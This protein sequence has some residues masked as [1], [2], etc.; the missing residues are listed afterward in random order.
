MSPDAAQALRDMLRSDAA[1]L[2]VGILVTAIGI[3]GLL[4]QGLRRASKDRGLVWFGLFAILYGIRLLITTGLSADL[5]G[6][7]RVLLFLIWA[8]TFT[9]GIP[10]AI[11]AWGLVSSEWNRTI[12]ILLGA[13][14]ALAVLAIASYP[15]ASLR[16]ALLLINN[17]LVI[18][19][20]SAFLV[21]LFFLRPTAVPGLKVLRIGFGLFALFV[22]YTNL[23]SANLMPGNAGLE[24]V[25][26]F[27]YI[28][29]LGY[30]G[31]ERMF[32]NEEHLLAIR[33]EL[34]IARQI[35]A[36][37]LPDR[38]PTITGLQ[39]AARYLPMTEVAGDFYEFLVVDSQRLG[40]LIADV[41]GHGVPAALVA[42]MLKVAIAAQAPHADDPAQVMS[43]L[44]SIL[45]GKLQ[46]QFITA[47]YLF[48]DLNAGTGLYSAAGHPPLLH[49][50]AAE[51]AIH[52]VESNGLILGFLPT[53][54][55]ESKALLLGAN[56]RFLLY[57]DGVLEASRNG[58]EFGQ[59]RL[60]ELFGVATTADQICGS[61][62]AAVDHWASGVAS[63]DI[64]VVAMQLDLLPA[65]PQ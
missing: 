17:L 39:L 30:I 48:L 53:A 47:G 31:A 52:A 65:K 23:V 7:R 26:F 22:M 11:F 35:Q 29:F 59:A 49:Y 57:T 42:S 20:T 64:T 13:I 27:I 54:V 6:S 51:T 5:V 2:V 61:V 4:L 1:P 44:N 15:V 62:T 3:G 40:I 34:E 55:Y 58:E 9:I 8:I 41:S 19:F 24:F 33:K 28:C 43:G 12:R 21:Y 50:C 25:G 16:P 32:R 63:D 14:A 10:A 36:S 18:G 46:G 38:M 56:D 60:L 45:T 37:I